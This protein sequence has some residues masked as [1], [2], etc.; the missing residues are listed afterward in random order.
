M[1]V[2]SPSR[3]T[4]LT[5]KPPFIGKQNIAGLRSLIIRGSSKLIIW[6]NKHTCKLCKCTLGRPEAGL[7]VRG[8]VP[9]QGPGQASSRLSSVTSAPSPYH[10]EHVI[11]GFASALRTP[12]CFLIYSPNADGVSK[13]VRRYPSC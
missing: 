1:P 8:T 9:D 7:K 13:V 4:F 3:T 5:Q 11:S 10:A 12:R 2:S 6:F